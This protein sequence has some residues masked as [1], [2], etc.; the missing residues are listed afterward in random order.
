MTI[1]IV[2]VGE[3]DI[4]WRSNRPVGA[5]IREAIER[6]L[7]DAGLVESDVDGFVIEGMG[8]NR[9]TPVDEVAFSMGLK[10]RPFAA[11]ISIAGSG[12]VAAPKLARLAIEAGLASVVVVYYGLS[13]SSIEGGPYSFHAED[14]MKASLEMPFGWFGQPTYFG[15]MAARY[16]YQYGL[17][18]EDLAV[19]AST[20]RE[21]AMRTPG[22]LR[23]DPLPMSKYLDSPYVAEPLRKVDCCLSNDSAAAYVITSIERARDLSKAPVVVAGVGL[24][25]LPV[26]QTQYFTQNPD[27]LSTAARK[28]GPMAMNEAGIGVT[29]VDIAELYDCFTIT[30]I[31]QLEDLGF[32]DRGEGGSFAREA[33]IGA[34]GALPVNTHGGLLAHSYTGSAN[35]VVEAVRQLRGER[36]DGQIDD[37]EVA[38]ITG[39]G[40][41]DHATLVLTRDR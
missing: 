33:G 23:T 30:T 8:T 41:P 29:D 11:Q 32:A 35:H 14:Q 4:S 1:A 6:A 31:L 17:D 19:I 9:F 38:L 13:L 28:S 15:A 37:V 5:L 12:V 40:I 3:S 26:T 25:S 36:G 27:Y 22:A 24:A 10:E 7:S 18:S 2:G 34:H 21:Y 16:R 39:L 20:A